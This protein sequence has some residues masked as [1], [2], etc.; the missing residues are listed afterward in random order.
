MSV[1]VTEMTRRF[2]FLWFQK[3]LW[4]ALEQEGKHPKCDNCTAKLKDR[5]QDKYIEESTQA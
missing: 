5:H 4:E 1:I 2:E 3:L